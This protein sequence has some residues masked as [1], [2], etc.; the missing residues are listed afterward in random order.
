M[1]ILNL[2][3]T[4]I[5]CVPLNQL[6]I[7]AAVHSNGVWTCK[8]RKCASGFQGCLKTRKYRINW[9]NVDS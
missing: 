5:P 1:K 3:N 8:L 7:E 6:G 9:A 4:G 2:S